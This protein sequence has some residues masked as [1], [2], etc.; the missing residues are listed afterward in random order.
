MGVILKEAHEEA[1]LKIKKRSFRFHVLG[2]FFTFLLSLSLIYGKVLL[3]ME[4]DLFRESYQVVRGHV[5]ET[6]AKLKLLEILRT[7]P[8]SIGQALEVA[9]VIFEESIA[10]EIPMPMVLAIIDRESSYRN[11]VVSEKGARGLMQLMPATWNRYMDDPE[12]KKVMEN[13]HI[14]ALNI[15]AGMAYL[16]DLMEKEK[17]WNR[18]LSIYVSGN[19]DTVSNQ[20]YIKQVLRKAE[21]YNEALQR[22]W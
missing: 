15:R 18:A 7:K 6:K 9:E 16:G 2:G 14:P 17:D 1:I 13:S 12:L 5:I 19:K 10:R 11:N 4:K 21:E 8:M 3:K 20:L 22:A